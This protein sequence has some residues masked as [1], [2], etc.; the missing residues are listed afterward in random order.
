MN[1][2]FLVIKYDSKA[3]FQ[4]H[5]FFKHEKIFPPTQAE[6]IE[7]FFNSFS[8]HTGDALEQCY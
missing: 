7:K 3:F 6:P 2:L 4:I 5:T 1:D 8:I